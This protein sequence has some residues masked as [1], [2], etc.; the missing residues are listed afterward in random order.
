M[1]DWELDDRMF[2][3]SRPLLAERVEQDDEWDDYDGP[4]DPENDPYL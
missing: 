4:T 2:Q 3:E 1:A